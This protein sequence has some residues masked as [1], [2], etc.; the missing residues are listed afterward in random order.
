[1][2]EVGQTHSGKWHAMHALLW[3]WKAQIDMFFVFA[4]FLSIAVYV[5]ST[6]FIL[7]Y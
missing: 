3:K 4:L 6:V 1:M 5:G 2:Q 7:W